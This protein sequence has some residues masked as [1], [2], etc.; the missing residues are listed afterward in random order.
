MA[1]QEEVR[2][3]RR[4]VDEW[5]RRASEGKVA[6]TD[7]QRSYVWDSGRAAAYIEAILR[8]KPVGLYLILTKSD[9]PQFRARSFNNVDTPLDDVHE[10][11]LDG[12]QRLTSL[13][14]GLYGHASRRFYIEVRELSAK[15]LELV[16]VGW[17]N[18]N[19]AKGK[20]LDEPGLAYRDN[21]IPLDIVRK[22]DPSTEELSPLDTWCSAVGDAV[23]AMEGTDDRLLQQRIRAFVD[24]RLFGRDLWFC[25]LPS[26][27]DR[28]E[29]TDIFVDTN[30]SSVKINRFDI[31]V[32]SARGHHD[33]N[34]REKI[35]DA[36]EDHVVLRHYFAEDPEEWVPNI[37][38][39]MLKVAC[40]HA[41]RPPKEGNYGAAL[42]YLFPSG[43][44]ESV[45]VDDVFKDMAWA[46][47]KVE[48]LG[49]ATR[50]TLPSWPP[51]HV[52]AALRTQYI[53]IRDPAT[54][55]SA[56]RLLEA[57]Y[58]RCL[59]SSRHEIHANERLFE[60]FDQL[61]KA[62]GDLSDGMSELAVFGEEDYGV[63]DA[64]QL[65]KRTK[66]I[67]SGGRLGRG[68]VSAI[69]S[70]ST[71]PRDWMTGE[72]LN[73]TKVRELE[74]SRNLDRHHVFPKD[75]LK[76]GG[77]GTDLI[78]NGLNGVLLERRTNLKV[79]RNA[80]SHYWPMMLEELDV[81]E[82]EVRERIE[83]H[84]IPFEEMTASSGTIR[85]RYE[86]FLR[87]RAKLVADKIAILARRPDER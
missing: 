17:E 23:E 60:D 55:D 49:A 11:V 59:F 61:R 10:L 69:M 8:G 47:R 85:R 57:Y 84:G 34:L 30:T 82:Q 65:F 36:Y 72:T 6:I 71:T 87:A 29:A 77:V 12:Q 75:C 35:Q 1:Q 22:H 39:W 38:E 70:S 48:G 19:T 26:T 25:L 2:Y 46:L 63:Y 62:L 9:P 44:E 76:R 5:L 67:G 86:R 13:L 7:F 24:E 21:R 73:A 54:A 4:S 42:E 32:A 40:L 33:Q 41:N 37:G 45:R 66:W 18:K 52:M 27:T 81:K 80:P 15:S 3:D 83:G 53:A 50:R 28:T 51:V 56:R 43:S 78:R 79:W 68:V 58:W 14:Q 74:G 16:E 31:E 20:R 64:D